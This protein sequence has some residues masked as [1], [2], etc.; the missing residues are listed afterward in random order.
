MTVDLR[1]GKYEIRLSR[2]NYHEWEAQLQLDEEGET[3]LFVKLI[4][5]D[6]S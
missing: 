3:P 2:H 4:S 6:D 1:L 5:M